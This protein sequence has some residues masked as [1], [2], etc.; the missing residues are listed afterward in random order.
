MVEE[1]ENNF[2]VLK[3]IKT[4]KKTLKLTKKNMIIY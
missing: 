2:K 3:Y 1:N 4:V